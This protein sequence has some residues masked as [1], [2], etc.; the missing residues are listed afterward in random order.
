MLCTDKENFKN[1]SE[2]SKFNLDKNNG[3]QS[4]NQSLTPVDNDIF[5]SYTKELQDDTT[6]YDV[7]HLII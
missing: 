1:F 7:T 6:M 4:M 5:L 2:I 3:H